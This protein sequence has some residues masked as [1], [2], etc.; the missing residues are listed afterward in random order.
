MELVVAILIAGPL[1]YFAPTARQGLIRYLVLAAVVFPI[2]TVAVNASNPEDINAGYFYF[3]AVIIAG[4]I[5]LNQAGH[6]LHR[7]RTPAKP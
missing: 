5:A 6:R 2:Q 7:R 3:N 1:G 4:G